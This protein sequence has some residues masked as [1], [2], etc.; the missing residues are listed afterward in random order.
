MAACRNVYGG[1]IKYLLRNLSVIKY[2]QFDGEILYDTQPKYKIAHITHKIARITNFKIKQILTGEDG[3]LKLNLLIKQQILIVKTGQFT[4][5]CKGD[6]V[7]ALKRQISL[8]Q[9]SI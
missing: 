9:D 3:P 8:W 6:R 1:C 5:K 4:T 7:T 2:G